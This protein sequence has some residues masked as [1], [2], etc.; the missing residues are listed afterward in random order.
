MVELKKGGGVFLLFFSGLWAIVYTHAIIVGRAFYADGPFFFLKCL[1]DGYFNDGQRQR[2]LVNVV[3]QF[4]LFVATHLGLKSYTLLTYIFSW[5]LF[6][7]PLILVV[8][9][10]LMLLQKNKKELMWL[11][12]AIYLFTAVPSIIF[13]INQAFLFLGLTILSVTIFM[14]QKKLTGLNK[15]V[16][17][18][19]A[20]IM[21]YGHETAMFTFPIFLGYCL[22]RRTKRDS[23]NFLLVLSLIYLAGFIFSVRWTTGAT[24]GNNLY[25]I[26]LS[27]ILS[28]KLFYLEET[29]LLYVVGG[30]VVISVNFVLELI[31]KKRWN[32]GINSIKIAL[33][34]LLVG[35]FGWQ[36]WQMIFFKQ[37]VPWYDFGLRLLLP[38]GSI[39]MALCLLI[40]EKILRIVFRSNLVKTT[41]IIVTIYNSIWQMNHSIGWQRFMD[42]AGKYIQ[43][44]QYSE[45]V[46][47]SKIYPG[48][49]ADWPW[50]VISMILQKGKIKVIVLP[51]RTE[52]DQYIKIPSKPGDSLE[53]PFS[54]WKNGPYIDIS[55]FRYKNNI[56]ERIK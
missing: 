56:N 34:L 26:A 6:F 43:T 53:T 31:S 40:P 21:F 27:D 22:Y 50:P 3:N 29:S 46:D 25:L 2:L 7:F 48:Y 45:R 1:T 42:S 38:I 13:V 32:K 16:L 19:A 14:V 28:H 36:L 41:L 23:D 24:S 5:P 12:I 8:I 47:T 11:P 9:S 30:V 44:M 18:V 54:V 4:P 33:I 15:F 20:I 51:K 37:P 10:A 17:L 52:F 49:D 39:A 35:F 55:G